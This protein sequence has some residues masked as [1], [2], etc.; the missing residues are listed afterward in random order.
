MER[1]LENL[2]IGAFAKAA[3][4][5]VET[6]RFYQRKGLLPEPDKPYGSIRRYGDADVTRVR[7]VK[8]AQRLGFSLDEIAEL[9]LLEDG[10]HCEEAGSLAEHKLNDV[11]AKLADLTRME[12]V[13]SELVCACHARQGNVSCPLIASLQAG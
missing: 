12:A 13:L 6:I 1:N 11:R 2:T 3:E 4:V 9:L 8:A 10:T 7:F 5:N